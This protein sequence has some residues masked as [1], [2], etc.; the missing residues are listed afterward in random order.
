MGVVMKGRERM[1]VED[2]RCKGMDIHKN[3]HTLPPDMDVQGFT[4]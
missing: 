4:T 2:I 3:A 1:R